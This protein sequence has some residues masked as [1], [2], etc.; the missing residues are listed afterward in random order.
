M[1]VRTSSLETVFRYGSQTTNN[2]T[3]SC[4]R[5][6]CYLVSNSYRHE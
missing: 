1:V 5:S 6:V 4:D 2:R 3:A